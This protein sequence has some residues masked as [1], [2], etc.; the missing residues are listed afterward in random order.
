MHKERP[1]RDSSPGLLESEAATL[2]PSQ[3]LTEHLPYA[4]RWTHR[5]LRLPAVTGGA[6][7]LW[8]RACVSLLGLLEAGCHTSSGLEQ[9]TFIVFELGFQ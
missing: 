3:T 7:G 9:Q 1:S 8:T 4:R 6:P 5:R 2:S